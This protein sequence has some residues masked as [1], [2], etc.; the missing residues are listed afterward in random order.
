MLLNSLV[1]GTNLSN[2]IS[3]HLL[4][5]HIDDWVRLIRCDFL[6]VFFSDLRGGLG[7]SIVKSRSVLVSSTIITKKKNATCLYC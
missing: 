2:G 4:D 5:E 3:G 1:T 7:V 6:L